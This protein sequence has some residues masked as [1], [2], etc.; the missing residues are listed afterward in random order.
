MRGKI[1]AGNRDLA[2]RFRLDG[3]CHVP[4]RR[5]Q[6]RVLAIDKDCQKLILSRRSQEAEEATWQR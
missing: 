3:F 6:F 4:A 5:R 2:I 1:G